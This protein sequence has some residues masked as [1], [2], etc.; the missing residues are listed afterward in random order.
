MSNLKSLGLGAISRITTVGGNLFLYPVLISN[1]DEK[2]FSLW[3]VFSSFYSL[4][5][6]I[7]FGFSATFGR[8]INYENS[9]TEEKKENKLDLLLFSN[10]KFFLLS[11]FIVLIICIL[12]HFFYISSLD[13]SGVEKNVTISWI[14]FSISLILN[15][16]SLELNGYLLGCNNL[17]LLYKTRIITSIIYFILAFIFLILNFGL[18]GLCLSKLVSAIIYR[19]ISS[20]ILPKSF[21]KSKISKSDLNIT[22]K[23]IAPDAIKIGVGGLGIYLISRMYILYLPK[24]MDLAEMASYSLYFNLLSL[25]ASISI[26]AVNNISPQLNRL[27]YKKDNFEFKRVYYKS[28]WTSVLLYLCQVLVLSISFEYFVTLF[29]KNYHLPNTKWIIMIVFCFL[30]EIINLSY[31]QVLS[32]YG[33]VNHGPVNFLIGIMIF[34]ISY[35]LIYF[36]MVDY[37]TLLYVN[38]SYYIIFTLFY[39]RKQVMLVI[40]Q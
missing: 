12:L 35:I 30:C 20:R 21:L 23:K 36:N 16:R 22:I 13:V 31:Y 33:K 7:D 28:V 8:Y 37:V 18:I 38:I 25:I 26:M 9:E 5:I 34:S 15:F 40:R 24:M 3:M 11:S 19:Y 4:I 17:Q 14:I 1:I 32:S 2:N 29:G 6:L 27:A 39:W 10:Y